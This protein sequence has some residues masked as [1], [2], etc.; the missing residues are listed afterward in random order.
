MNHQNLAPNI[1]SLLEF[2]V[3]MRSLTAL[4][5]HTIVRKV[6]RPE[7]A[8]QLMVLLFDTGLVFMLNHSVAATPALEPRSRSQDQT[9]NINMTAVKEGSLVEVRHSRTPLNLILLADIHLR[10]ST[11]KNT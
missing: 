6:G 11:E 10:T 2:A 3:A 1:L 4:E 5:S 7:P 8:L 9:W